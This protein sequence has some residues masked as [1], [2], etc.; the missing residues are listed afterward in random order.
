[1]GMIGAG[2][3]AAQACAK[4][5]A[6]TDAFGGVG[7]AKE[8][9]EDARRPGTRPP[10]GRSSDLGRNFLTLLGGGRIDTE[11]LETLQPRISIVHVDRSAAH[12][13]RQTLARP[14]VG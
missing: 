4:V 3:L 8:L 2:R 11:Y 6:V 7:H 13:R 10:A 12:H 9:R 14:S 5:V 1:R